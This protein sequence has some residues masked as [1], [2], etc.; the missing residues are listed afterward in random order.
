MRGRGMIQESDLDRVPSNP[1]PLRDVEGALSPHSPTP[2]KPRPDSWNGWSPEMLGDVLRHRASSR[3]CWEPQ[4]PWKSLSAAL[5]GG[6]GLPAWEDGAGPLREL[7]R[8]HFKSSTIMSLD[9]QG[10]VSLRQGTRKCQASVR[11]PQRRADAHLCAETVKQN[12]KKRTVR[13]N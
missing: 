7:W 5:Q 4:L 13:C 12:Q 9:V 10:L 8:L 1:G 2:G 6:E 3:T 11:S